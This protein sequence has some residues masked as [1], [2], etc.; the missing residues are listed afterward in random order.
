MPYRGAPDRDV[1]VRL[2]E[3]GPDWAVQ[4]QTGPQP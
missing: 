4:P 2:T 1:W 3:V